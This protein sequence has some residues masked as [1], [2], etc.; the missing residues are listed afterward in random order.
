MLFSKNLTQN[1]GRTSSTPFSKKS[2]LSISL[3]QTV[4]NFIQFVFIVFPSRRLPDVIKLKCWPLVFA[5]YRAFSKI[6]ERL[7]LVFLPQFLYDFWRKIFLMLY[8]INWTNLI[9]WL[10]LF[11]EI[12]GTMCIAIICFLVYDAKNFGITLAFLSSRNEKSQDKHLNVIRTKRA[13]ARFSTMYT[14]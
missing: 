2:K 7:E 3:Y 14:L 5:S 4:S 11:L 10:S 12:L 13:I 1:L 6:K 8:S 9:T